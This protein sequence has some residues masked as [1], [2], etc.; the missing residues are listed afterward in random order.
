MQMA[1]KTP[2]AR[3]AF[4]SEL[5]PPTWRYGEFDLRRDAIADKKMTPD[6]LK[7]KQTLTQILEDGAGK[8]DEYE[9]FGGSSI[10]IASM[11]SDTLSR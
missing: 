9:N 4:F 7:K 8:E 11:S 3:T 6:K 1:P 2:S 5:A 10:G